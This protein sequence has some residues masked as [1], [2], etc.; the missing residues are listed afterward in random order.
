[1]S[2]NSIYAFF[3]IFQYKIFV[4]FIEFKKWLDWFNS[5]DYSVT[6]LKYPKIKKRAKKGKLTLSQ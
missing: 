4:G 3:K 6:D 1:M 2:S 5:Q